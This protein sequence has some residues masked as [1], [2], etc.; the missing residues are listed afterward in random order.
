LVKL[1]T[2]EINETARALER[3]LASAESVLPLFDSLGLSEEASGMLELLSQRI[4]AAG[5][6]AR[7][8]ITHE[9]ATPR[10]P[11]VL[12]VD[13]DELQLLFLKKSLEKG[14]LDVTTT[15]SGSMAVRQLSQQSF[16]LVILDCQMPI[17]DGFEV[18]KRI[19]SIDSARGKRTPMLAYTGHAIAGYKQLCLQSGMDEYLKKPALSKE[20]V[21]IARSLIA[22]NK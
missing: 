2:P 18:A 14:G 22:V 11:R 1:T 20:I 21:E 8:L 12:V 19:R 13:D 6:L 9:S 15:N 5:D 4:S 3:E 16:E 7:T 17:M 10:N